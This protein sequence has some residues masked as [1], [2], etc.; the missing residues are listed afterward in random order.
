MS[1][2][3][4]NIKLGNILWTQVGKQI[5]RDLRYHIDV[6]LVHRDLRHHID[7]TLANYEFGNQIVKAIAYVNS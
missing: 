3:Q 2:V 7:V 4:L 5:H 1:I 6:N